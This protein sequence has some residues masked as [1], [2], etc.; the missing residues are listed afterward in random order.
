MEA[1]YDYLHGRLNRRVANL[2]GIMLLTVGLL[3][4]ASGGAYYV[5]AAN[6]RS[7][8]VEMVSTMPVRTVDSI[9]GRAASNVH[10]FPG[11][12]VSAESW[13]NLFGYEPPDYRQRQLLTGFIPIDNSDLEIATIE[14]A[15]RIIIPSIGINSTITE[16]S[17]L[18]LGDSRYY[19]SPDHTVGHIPETGIGYENH[20]SW[21]FGHTESPISREGSVFF[22]LQKVPEKLRSGEEVFIITENGDSQ[23]LYRAIL[24]QVF[25]QNDLTLD[26]TPSSDIKLV[27]SVPRF[28]YDHR[29]VISGELIAIK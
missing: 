21:F 17:I 9:T 26:T 12:A 29:L 6:S 2:T 20:T 13:T 10:L 3:L 7:N 11:M 24:S 1:G 19:E 23:F 5:Y 28:V 27:S 15:T 8:L 14:P 25:H 4:L 16:L 18:D 22:N